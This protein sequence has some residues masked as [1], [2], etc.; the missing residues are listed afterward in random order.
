MMRYWI[1]SWLISV[2]IAVLCISK[3]TAMWRVK[4]QLGGSGVD[5]RVALYNEIGS[6][7]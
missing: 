5:G 6:E 4:H 3:Y 7:N 1:S 2:K